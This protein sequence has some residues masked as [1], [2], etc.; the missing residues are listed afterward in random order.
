MDI[1]IIPKNN[2]GGKIVV[3]GD[4]SISHRALILS[5]IAEGVT[6]ISGF[7]VAEDCLATMDC[8][9]K[10]GVKIEHSDDVARVFGVGLYGLQKPSDTLYAGNSGTTLRLLMG[11]L[12]GQAFDAILDGDASIRRRPMGRVV[13]PL[14]Q[15]GANLSGN[16]API[17]IK[18]TKLRGIHYKMPIAS[19]QVKS[20]ILLA[21]LYAQG[22]TIVEELA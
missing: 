4:K 21:A 18:G 19:A 13:T 22:E 10:L 8:L 1:K 9:R 7:L 3:P 16:A 17:S 15:M 5:A 12:A 14:S 6:E 11:L 2:I 20:S